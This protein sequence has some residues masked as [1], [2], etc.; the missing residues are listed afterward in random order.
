MTRPFNL[1]LVLLATFAIFVEPTSGQEKYIVRLTNGMI[2]GPGLFSEIDTLSTNGFQ[3]GGG[4][5]GPRSIG[6]VDDGLRKTYFNI[7]P[8]NF[9]AEES[10][11]AA[12]EEIVTVAAS[13]V[14]SSGAAP[15]IQAVLR[16]TPFNKFGR[17]EFQILT[18][19]GEVD[20]LQGITLLTPHYTKVEVLNTDAGARFVWDTRISTSAIP[21]EELDAILKHALGMEASGDWLQIVRFYTQAERFNLARDTMIEGLQKFPSALAGRMAIVDQLDQFYANDK[22]AEIKLRREAGQ[23]AL[24]VKYLNAFPTEVLPVESQIKLKDELNAA[25]NQITLIANIIEALKKRVSQLPT[26]EQQSVAPLLDEI[27]A[28]IS[29]NTID[30]FADF[31]RLRGDD[32]IPNENKVALAFSG[33]LLGPNAGLDNFAVVK[34]VIKVRSL[35]REY[36]RDANQPR[37]QAILNQLGKEE[38]AQPKLVDQI[39]ETMQPPL[40]P[41]TPQSGDPQGMFRDSVKS[42]HSA[43][44]DYVVQ[45]PPEYDPN[46]KY[47]CILALP[48]RGDLPDLEINVWC[49]P[50]RELAV[51]KA[52]TGQATR[53]GYIVVSP[54]WMLEDQMEYNYTEGEHDRIL[55]CMRDALRKYSID[56]DRV[57]IAGHFAGATAAWD[58]ASSHPDLWAGAIMVSPSADK[59]IVQYHENLKSESRQTAPLGMYI[60]YGELDG[61]RAASKVGSVLTNYLKFPKTDAMAVEYRGRGSG[62]FMDEL[63]RIF[64]WMSLS[65]HRRI[66]T[67]QKLS[68]VTMR[69]GDRFFYWL[70]APQLLPQLSGNAFQFDAKDASKRGTFSA[71]LLGPNFNGLSISKIPSVRRQATVWLTPDMVDFSR[72]ISVRM[73]GR[74]PTF[75]VAPDVGVMLEDARTRGD[76]M[77]VFWQKLELR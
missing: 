43:N 11:R 24:A 34:S 40:S 61:T 13:E 54:K 7:S 63:D 51:T 17:R 30:R 73:S 70:E 1:T 12:L 60:V 62:L 68:N 72:P 59:Y 35:V 36:L 74:S 14:A 55:R 58:L 45:V 65:T 16:V 25:R 46:R 39:L 19:R 2:L 49:G 37:R 6:I 57:F 42:S 53:N 20:V 66:R 4:S 27:V 67:P 47:P 41:P 28:E 21:N 3:K 38:G 44:V 50:V 32:S 56:S 23:H 31:Q 48:G 75:D 76:R 8:I 22:F 15:A 9:S 10:T 5:N 77:H 64:E 69:N 18:P 33:W 52:R 26:T 71:S 29:P